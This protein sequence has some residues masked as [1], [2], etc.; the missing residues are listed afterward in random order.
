M[1]VG[2]ASENDV[3]QGDGRPLAH[4]VEDATGIPE[5]I[6]GCVK[7]GDC[8]R[9]HD[10]NPIVTDDSSETIYS[11]DALKPNEREPQRGHTYEQCT[12]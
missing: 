4:A 1:S 12:G 9:I 3:V 11:W 7:F 10:T 5:K 2:L 8:A 6:F